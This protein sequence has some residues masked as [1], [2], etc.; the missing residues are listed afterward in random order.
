[1]GCVFISLGMLI[2][3]LMNTWKYVV[4]KNTSVRRAPKD[5]LSN[6]HNTSLVARRTKLKTHFII[7]IHQPYYQSLSTGNI[8]DAGAMQIFNLVLTKCPSRGFSMGIP[9]SSPRTLASGERLAVENPPRFSG[10]M[11]PI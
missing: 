11:K 6:P 10:W 8:K 7:R 2:H 3:V 5:S 1:M 9:K 4:K